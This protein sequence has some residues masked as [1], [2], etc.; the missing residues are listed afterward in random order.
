MPQPPQDEP[1]AGGEL[2]AGKDQAVR[3][4]TEAAELVVG[5]GRE[6]VPRLQ[7]EVGG[8]DVPPHPR[9]V[10]DRPRL[11]P[12]EAVDRLGGDPGGPGRRVE[13]TAGEGVGEPSGVPDED[14]PPPLEPFGDAQGYGAA[15]LLDDFALDSVLRY[16]SLQGWDRPEAADVGGAA[17]IFEEDPAGVGLG[18]EVAVDDG[19][20]GVVFGPGHLHLGCGKEPVSGSDR[21]SD[22]GGGAVGPHDRLCPDDLAPPEAEDAGFGVDLLDLQGDFSACT[23]R[24][25]QEMLVEAGPIEHQ[26]LSSHPV[27]RTVREYHLQVGDLAGDEV[28]DGGLKLRKAGGKEPLGALLG[29]P[30]HLFS[31]DEEDLVAHLR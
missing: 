5:E 11:S 18:G 21:P 17:L 26:H 23:L 31:V 29:D 28:A 22:S 3:G 14:G 16:E 6:G 13:A 20:Y 24:Q 1:G 25:P 9:L 2:E 19:V 30:H 8:D 12:E 7:M 4:G 15:V 10:L 27:A